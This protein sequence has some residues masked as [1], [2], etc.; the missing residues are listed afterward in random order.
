M[1][2]ETK[3]CARSLQRLVLR[4]IWLGVHLAWCLCVWPFHF[5][6]F[7]CYKVGEV[8]MDQFTQPLFGNF[9][10]HRRKVL[11]W[12]SENEVAERR[13]QGKDANV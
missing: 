5:A 11:L 6:F 12:E 7:V 13:A 8:G 10:E 1:S 2:K 9:G 3:R 4:R